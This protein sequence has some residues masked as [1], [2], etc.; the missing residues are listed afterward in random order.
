MSVRLPV[1]CLT[2]HTAIRCF[3]AAFASKMSCQTALMAYK[4]LTGTNQYHDL[5]FNVGGY[6]V[7]IFKTAFSHQ[8][9][10]GAIKHFAILR[11]KHDTKGK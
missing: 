4:Q 3:L 11:L 6:S 1:F 5:F 10:Q 7:R 2:F 8:Y 9:T